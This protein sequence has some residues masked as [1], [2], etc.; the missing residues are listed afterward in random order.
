MSNIVPTSA[1]VVTAVREALILHRGTTIESSIKRATRYVL[2]AED[3]ADVD[4]LSVP[5]DRLTAPLLKTLIK[6]MRVDG[7]APQTINHTL[8]GIRSIVD[9]LYQ[10][11]LMEPL[12]YQG[13]KSVKGVKSD[14]R[15]TGRVITPD[16][17][18]RMM[19]A[20]AS[21]RAK[22]II[23]LLLWGLRRIEVQRLNIGNITQDEDGTIWVELMGKGMKQRRINIAGQHAQLIWTYYQERAGRRDG[24]P[25]FSGH[26]GDTELGRIT[27]A[28]ITWIFNQ[29]ADGAG[30]DATPHD[31]RR[32][33]VTEMSEAGVPLMD[34]SK[35]VGHAKPETTF[36]YFKIDDSKI[37]GAA[38]MMA[39]KRG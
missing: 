37:K 9:V 12:Q 36:G 20:A 21:P 3:G 19:A 33:C 2:D 28:G 30:V 35:Y 8:S 18:T 24:S 11:G 17:Q 14:G 6:R 1:P 10:A 31:L 7:L 39:A 38:A 23:A 34:I 13:V 4:P 15:E 16:E 25:L 27:T 29:V 22:A 26:T 5:W 32:T